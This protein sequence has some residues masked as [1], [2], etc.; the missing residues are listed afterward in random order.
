[1]TL[2]SVL[3]V[4]SCEQDSNLDAPREFFAKH[5][6]GSSPDWGIVKWGNPTDHV[7]TV[8]GF[9]DDYES[10]QILAAALNVDA[11]NETGGQNCLNP[12]SC[13]ALNY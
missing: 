8:H 12:F 5:K 2:A 11:C 13:D 3:L 1:M 4:A 6:I 10:C 7:V 9:V